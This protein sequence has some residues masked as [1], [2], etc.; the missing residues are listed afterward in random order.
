MRY[1]EIDPQILPPDAPI[2]AKDG[3]KVGELKDFWQ[4]AYSN[5]IDN[6]ARGKLAEYLIACALGIEKTPTQPWAAF[7]LQSKEGLAIEVKTSGYLQAWG[8]NELSKIVF[9]IPQT[10]GW[11]GENGKYAEGL[12]RQSDLYIFCV[13]NH[14]EQET[15]NPLFSNRTRKEMRV[16]AFHPFLL[17]IARM[18]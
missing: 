16:G 12:K 15:I 13:H 5:L 3:S 4:W 18:R 7:D 11:D 2:L 6:T 8:Q 17:P 14:K 9:G 1:P 10:H